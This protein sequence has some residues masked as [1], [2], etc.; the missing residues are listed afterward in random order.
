MKTAE[1]LFQEILTENQQNGWLN[2]KFHAFDSCLPH[3][4]FFIEL[5]NFDRMYKSKNVSIYGIS[6]LTNGFLV[7]CGQK[8][9]DE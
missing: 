2:S 9:E 6:K 7:T 1:E 5:D 8:N 4:R 3:K